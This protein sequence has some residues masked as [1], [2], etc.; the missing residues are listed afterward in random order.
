MAPR[1][2]SAAA[3]AALVA[4]LAGP[5]T[6]ALW[7]STAYYSESSTCAVP[8]S[9]VT[10]TATLTSCDGDVQPCSPTGDEHLT[11]IV[12]CTETA[13][14]ENPPLPPGRYSRAYAQI[15]SYTNSDCSGDI[16]TVQYLPV[17][18]CTENPAEPESYMTVIADLTIYEYRSGCNAD[19]SVCTTTIEEAYGFCGA[20][21]TGQ[22]INLTP[23]LGLD[24][25]EQ[26]YTI[27]G[28][29]ELATVPTPGAPRNCWAVPADS[30]TN[31]VYGGWHIEHESNDVRP[32]APHGRWRWP[33]CRHGLT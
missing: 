21:A 20:P 31:I 12:G 32:C 23:Q 29:V 17:G 15:I 4:A 26:A 14:H 1:V 28:T 5:A 8:F 6:A 10:Y 19:C 13:S 11:S 2:A 18:V 25:H 24:V 33:P 3:L 27:L 22:Q 7:Q 16:T 30:A 9:S